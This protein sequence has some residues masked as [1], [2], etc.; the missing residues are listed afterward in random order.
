MV[1]GMKDTVTLTDL[2]LD[3][4]EKALQ[5]KK[6]VTVDGGHFD[7]YVSQFDTAAGAARNWFTQHLNSGQPN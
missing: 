1:V 2:A 3:A 6:L 4:Y 5:P 7:P